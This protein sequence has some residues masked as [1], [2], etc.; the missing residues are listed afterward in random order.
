MFFSR[1]EIFPRFNF[2]P[3]TPVLIGWVLSHSI[4]SASQDFVAH[5]NKSKFAA[6]EYLI[7]VKSVDALRSL[8]DQFGLETSQRPLLTTKEGQW[9]KVID[10]DA[11]TNFDE[12]QAHIYS[13]NFLSENVLHIEKNALWHALTVSADPNPERPPQLPKKA[14]RDP[15]LNRAYGVLK[16]QAPDAW[17][18]HIGS[19]DVV[20]ADIDTGVDYNHQDLINNIWRNSREIPGDK[21]D[22]DGNG[23][24]DDVVG[25]DFANKDSLPWD[26]NGHGTHT[27]GS[28]AATG[29]NGIGVSG[30]AQRAQVMPLKFLSA[31]GSGTT[32]DAVLA[33][34]YAVDNGAK[35]LSNSWGGDE[36]SKALEDVIVEAA[37]R[38]VLFV[39]A[40][41]NDGT[42]NDTLPMYP[43][44][45]NLPNVIA[46]AASDQDDTLVDYSNYGLN[47]VHIVAPGDVIYSTVPGNKYQ[48]NSGTS[49]ACPHVAGAAALLK[50]YKPNLTAVQIKKILL[51][52]VDKVPAYADKIASGGRLNVARAM[53]K[54]AEEQN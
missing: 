11:Q 53:F 49:M 10:H 32:E 54:A 37:N 28:I 14:K 9:F 1:Q 13:V 34:K 45:Y 24:V 8:V 18:K 20:I 7:K 29:G 5:A 26:D 6:D 16:I 25:W 51:D 46:V 44:A 50:S 15:L 41:G 3:V 42:N 40:A 33:I 4:A 52:S 38:Q 12:L 43:A 36:Y 23:F 31:D 2:K 39:A 19:A 27:S 48:V 21:I 30:V 22:N 35:I 17:A 47:S